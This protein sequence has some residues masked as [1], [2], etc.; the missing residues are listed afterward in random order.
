[1][2]LSPVALDDT[3]VSVHR[4][5]GEGHWSLAHRVTGE[6]VPLPPVPA[7]SEYILVGDEGDLFIVVDDQDD[8][9]PEMVE[10]KLRFRLFVDADDQ[11]MWVRD[12]ASGAPA[13]LLDQMRQKHEQRQAFVK[14]PLCS[15]EVSLECAIYVLPVAGFYIRFSMLRLFYALALSGYGGHAGRW[16]RSCADA[17]VRRANKYELPS[18]L[19][20]SRQY[21]NSLERHGEDPSRH[22][23]WPSCHIGALVLWLLV[24]AFA[25]PNEG[26]LREHGDR[27][28]CA[29]FVQGLL[30][31]AFGAKWDLVLFL[32]ADAHRSPPQPPVGGGPRAIVVS[33]DGML[34]IGTWRQR[35]A[36]LLGVEGVSE[37]L[38]LPLL[39]GTGTM[40]PLTDVVAE[41]AGRM[42][43]SR[44]LQN[45]FAQFVWRLSERLEASHRQGA[46][47]VHVRL[48]AW[49]ANADRQRC[50]ML[51]GYLASQRSLGRHPDAL[52]HICCCIDKSRVSGLGLLN[53]AFALPENRAWWAPPQACLGLYTQTDFVT[54]ALSDIFNI[55]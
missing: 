43:S 46:S 44:R 23:G 49:G 53:G 30:Q 27:Q 9:E 36:A 7:A 8:I 6:V 17:L 14:L 4:T 10:S 47:L 26:G 51:Q 35:C 5:G 1:M 20:L 54:D 50:E 24:W 21:A 15:S 16:V 48:D 19:H 45:I 34:D 31:G 32:A 37:V 40:A 42:C 29:F 18:S 12:M 3:V 25:R 28:T 55:S 2:V 39:S 33:A 13:S 52:L 41:V 11:Q 22:L 38:G